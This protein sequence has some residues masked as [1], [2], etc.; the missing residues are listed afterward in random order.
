MDNP[1]SEVRIGQVLSEIFK[2]NKVYQPLEGGTEVKT[3]SIICHLSAKCI[4]SL[5]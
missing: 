3:E 2:T 1:N 5:P 4:T